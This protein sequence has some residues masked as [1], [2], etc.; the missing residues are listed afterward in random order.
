VRG[1][2]A[3]FAPAR[4]TGARGRPLGPPGAAGPALGWAQGGR[5]LL[6]LERRRLDRGAAVHRAPALAATP[7]GG[8]LAVAWRDHRVVHVVVPGVRAGAFTASGQVVTGP[9][10]GVDAAGTP[11]VAWQDARGVLAAALGGRPQRLAPSSGGAL[12][13][14]LAVGAGGDALVTVL[15]PVP[16]TRVDAG[17]LVT[18]AL[19]PAGGAFREPVTLSRPGRFTSLA[20]PAFSPGGT[21]LVAWASGVATPQEALLLLATRPVAAASGAGAP[22]APPAGMPAL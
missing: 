1:R 14:G 8:R 11:T 12:L 21:A 20:T 22:A 3:R 9:L 15:D 5:L 4:R 18:A 13:S 2:D 19:R 7:D 17:D 16:S 10:V 6:R